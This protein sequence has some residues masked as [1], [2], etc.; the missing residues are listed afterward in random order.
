LFVECQRFGGFRFLRLDAGTQGKSL[1]DALGSRQRA[2]T[3]ARAL[4]ESGEEDFLAVLDAEREL[5]TAEDEAALS[6]T[7]S[8]L[9]LI[10]LYAALGGG[11]EAFE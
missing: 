7:R 9:E 10:N 8:V 5:V 4:F 3:L 11:W 1:E 2:V 6:Q